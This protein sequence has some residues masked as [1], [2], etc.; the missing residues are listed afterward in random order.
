MAWFHYASVKAQRG[1]RHHH[2]LI[3]ARAAAH[4]GLRE[5][6][7]ILASWEALGA[8]RGS[9]GQSPATW[10]RQPQHLVLPWTAI[11]SLGTTQAKPPCQAGL[12]SGAPAALDRPNPDGGPGCLAPSGSS[13]SAA[14]SW[15]S[16]AIRDHECRNERCQGGGGDAAIHCAAGPALPDACLALPELCLIVRCPIGGV[17][18][19]RG[20]T[21]P[22]R[23][24]IHT[25]RPARPAATFPVCILVRRA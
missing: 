7:G 3:G 10:C 19:T 4:D 14:T 13:C 6:R 23:H 5:P 15:A 24:V 9:P 25:A 16:R 17:L 8:R 11:G 21:L 12:P 22:A 1:Q 2:H 20:G 18:V